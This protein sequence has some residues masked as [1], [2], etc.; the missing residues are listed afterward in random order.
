MSQKRHMAIRDI[1]D[2][3]GDDADIQ[4]R[5][6][7]PSLDNVF[8]RRSVF[9]AV[10]CKSADRVLGGRCAFSLSAGTDHAIA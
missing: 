7:E 4:V 10:G 9:Q 1:A 8:I 3:A 5:L 6:I 2:R